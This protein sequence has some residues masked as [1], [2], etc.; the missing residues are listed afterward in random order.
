MTKIIRYRLIQGLEFYLWFRVALG[1]GLIVHRAW[2]VHDRGWYA[3]LD[4]IGPR[5]LSGSALIAILL[6]LIGIYHAIRRGADNLEMLARQRAE[7]MRR[8]PG[9]SRPEMFPVTTVASD[10]FPQPEVTFQDDTPR[11]TETS[12]TA[13]AKQAAP[14]PSEVGSSI[15]V[16][17][18]GPAS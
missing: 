2:A 16:R 3:I 6:V 11:Y 9:V 1:L 7:T 13:P 14:S 10:M 4:T 17:R 18:L 15:K 8:L 12:V 5:F